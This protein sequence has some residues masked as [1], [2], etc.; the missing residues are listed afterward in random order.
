MEDVWYV[1]SWTF[2]NPGQVF[3]EAFNSLEEAKE[4]EL[5]ILNMG[6]NWDAYVTKCHPSDFFDDVI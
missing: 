5:E 2:D 4:R 3:D 1:Y 6:E